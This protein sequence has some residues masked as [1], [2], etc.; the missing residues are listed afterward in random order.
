[1]EDNNIIPRESGQTSTGSFVTRKLG[2]SSQEAKQMKAKNVLA[3]AASRAEVDWHAIN[4][5][6]ATG[7]VRRLQARIV[8]AT[9]AGRWGKVKA[10]Q[11]LLTRSFSGKA[12]AVRRVTENQGKNTPGVDQVIWNTPK[13]KAQAVQSLRQRGYH[14]QPLRRIYIAKKNSTK[15]RPLS[16]PAMF[17][18]AMQALY[19]LALDPVAET[20]A[21]P[22]S[23]GFRKERS[24]AD[25][26]ARCYQV[27][28]KR[29]SPRWILEGDIKSCFDTISH[30]WLLANI[31]I[32]KNLLRK[33]LTAGYMEKHA[34]YPTEE[35]TPQGGIASPVLMNMTLDGL[36]QELRRNFP[37]GAIP[38]PMVNFDRY[39]DDFITTGRSK[40][41]LEDQVLPVIEQFMQK[42]G[43]TLSR[44]KTKITRIEEGFDFL[45][46]N[47]R[48]YNDKLLIKPARKNVKAFLTKI[49]KNVQENRSATAGNLIV[50]L[51]PI[52]RGWA[53]YH[54]HVCS[55]VIFCKVDYAIFKAIWHWARRRHPNKGARWVKNKYFKTIGSRHWVFTGEVS[56]SQGETQS[57]LLSA[58]GRTPIRYH[59]KIKGAANP[60]DPEW[61]PYFEHQLG[62][63]MAD[64]LKGR[65]QLIQLWKAQ[66][67]LCPICNQKIT[68]L[69]GWHN[70]H[71]VWRTHGGSDGMNNRVLLHPECHRQV[72]SQDKTVVKPRPVIGALGKA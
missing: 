18:R 34:L 50:R 10:L 44:E 41:L 14:P 21:D 11:R 62:V 36:E 56:N 61:E 20:K 28:G 7:S 47:V 63:K 31:P 51:N 2:K 22:N 25:A 65:R 35:G 5:Q 72:H 1:M 49:R 9:Q 67:G 70:H 68:K 24:T 69:T 30:E 15:L 71:I 6:K 66:N 39:A 26:I 45:G 46:Q 60:Y 54:Q 3:C 27:L 4:W 43:L 40:E 13:K 32:E 58:A 19:L 53:R 29:N 8:K 37:G 16:I 48:K 33:W 55:K 23:Y 17:D 52:I 38:H 42:R 59:N 64:N 57:V 12:L